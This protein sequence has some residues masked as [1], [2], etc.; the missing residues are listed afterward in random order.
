MASCKR[1]GCAAGIPSK[2][3]LKDM[4]EGKTRSVKTDADLL[5]RK[6]MLK[7]QTSMNQRPLNVRNPSNG[8]K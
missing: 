8:K 3:D 1:R 5:G 4:R 7:D 2:I 6:P